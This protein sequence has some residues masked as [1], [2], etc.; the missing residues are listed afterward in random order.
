VFKDKNNN[1]K[2]AF[3][4]AGRSVNQETIARISAAAMPNKSFLLPQSGGGLMQKTI[5]GPDGQPQV[6]TG[7]VFTDPQTNTTYFQAGNKRYDTSGLSTPAQNVQNVYSAAAASSAGKA[8]GEG[9][10][11]QPLPAFPG[12]AGGNIPAAASGAVTVDPAAVRRAQSD[13]EAVD[14]EIKRV[15]PGAPGAAKTLETLQTE[16]AAAQQRLQQASSGAVQGLTA[17]AAPAVTATSPVW[18]Q[19]QQ[20]AVGE[21]TA[22][23]QIQVAGA[24]SKSFNEI[25][26]TEVRPQAQAGDTVSSTRKQ[27]FEIFDRPGVDMNKI[28]G[29]ANGAGR[30]P[31]D[32]SW[33]LVRDVLLGSYEGKVDDV[34]QRAAALGLNSAEQS[35]LAEYQ[36]ANVAVNSANLKKTAGPGSVSDAEQKVNREAGVDPTKVPALA[37]YNAMA[38][39]KFD[40]D[41]SRYKADWAESSPATNALQLDKA[42]RKESQS[43]TEVYTNIAKQRAKFIA[44][45]QSTT[46]A[47]KEG[48][49]RYPIPEYDPN[50]GQ[51]KKT[52]PMTDIFGK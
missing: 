35:A 41:K 43:L 25:L 27:Q 42:W 3:D 51:W 14:R 24:R 9:F 21:A 37:A 30:S 23:E 5:T 20:A 29:I 40:A 18:Q 12:Q 38:Q 36:I 52:K 49:K 26:D 39:S 47:V 34:K 46:M 2:E 8:G 10:T 7:Q 45:N 48:Y 19:R 22:K 15:K 16:R 44:D 13:V 31:S 11:P 32:Q 1:I 4:V 28:F 50:T 33:T 17:T 6:I